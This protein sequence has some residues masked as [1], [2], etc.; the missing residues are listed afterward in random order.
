MIQVILVF[1]PVNKYF[2]VIDNKK[3]ISSWKSKRL[4]KGTANPPAASDN[5]LSLLIDYLGA[6][7]RLKFN[8]FKIT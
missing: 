7:I 8:V 5:S 3:C 1:Q 2:Q 4:S 6:K